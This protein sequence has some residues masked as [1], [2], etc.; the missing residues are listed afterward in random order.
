MQTRLPSPA[1]ARRPLA[2]IRQTLNR[3]A[4]DVDNGARNPVA[5]TQTLISLVGCEGRYAALDPSLPEAL[6]V[7]R[8]IATDM[9]YGLHEDVS[10]GL[11]AVARQ[12]RRMQIG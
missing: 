8:E 9:A 7:A 12:A 11:H 1:A 6:H 3:L 5:A 2:E 4:A 10:S